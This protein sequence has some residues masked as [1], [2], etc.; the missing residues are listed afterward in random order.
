VSSCPDPRTQPRC[1][2]TK[3]TSLTAKPRRTEAGG[4]LPGAEDG[5]AD[6]VGEGE[7]AADA[8]AED[9]VEPE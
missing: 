3:L 4:L 7:A 9:G 5:A 8:A 1:A 6:A 2:D